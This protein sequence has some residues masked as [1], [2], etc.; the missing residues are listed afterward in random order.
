MANNTCVL[1]QS[2]H[3]V[4]VKPGNLM[5]I[6]MVKSGAEVFAFIE[7]G[8]PTQPGLKALQAQLLEQPLVVS[9]WKAPLVVMVRQKLRRAPTP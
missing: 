3:I 7:N 6:K 8:A 4:F 9:H 2:L 5:K 1:Q